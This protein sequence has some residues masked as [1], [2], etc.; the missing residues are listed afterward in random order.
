VQH[1]LRIQQE[2]S[3]FFVQFHTVN[4]PRF[5]QYSFPVLPVIKGYVK[6]DVEDPIVFAN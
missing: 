5:L 3:S 2:D 4:F 1:L 6:A